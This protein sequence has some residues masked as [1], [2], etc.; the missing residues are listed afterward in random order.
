MFN[1]KKCKTCI[2]HAKYSGSSVYRNNVT[3]ATSGG[4]FCGY[5]LATYHTC[6][7][8]DRQELVDRRGD[9]PENC[10]L[11]MAGKPKSGF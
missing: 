2:Y 8:Y 9:D 3:P 7:Q 1:K 10:R 11:Y 6:L 4:I 5:S